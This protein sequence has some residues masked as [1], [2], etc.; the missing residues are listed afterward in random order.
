[1]D[2][3]L[4][5]LSE[6]VRKRNHVDN[7]L[8]KIIGRSAEKGHLGEF[9][10]SHIFG[11]ELHKSAAYKGSDGLFKEGRL[12]GKSVNVKWYSLQEYIIDIREAFLP[13]YFLIM[14]GPLANKLRA[15]SRL[16]F[17]DS[18][19]LFDAHKL[20]DELK[21]KGEPVYEKAPTPIDSSYWK[22][23]ELYPNNSS[24]HIMPLIP[25]QIELLSLFGSRL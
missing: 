17:I 8:A 11:I 19:F 16:L 14:T 5:L 9:I 22:P 20:I 3:S 23:A 15:K 1:M 24:S 10:A 12:R 13:D 6:Y 21:V 2:E 7:E 25:Q 4:R 18:V